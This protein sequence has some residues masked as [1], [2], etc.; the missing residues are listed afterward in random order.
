MPQSSKDAKGGKTHPAKSKS[1]GKA[2]GSPEQDKKQTASLTGA[3][4]H[5]EK[6]TTP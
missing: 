1:G 2:A 6:K 4:R 3:K 5:G